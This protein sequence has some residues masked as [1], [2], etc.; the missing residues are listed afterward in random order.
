MKFSLKN[1]CVGVKQSFTWL[2]TGNHS[3]EIRKDQWVCDCDCFWD[4]P[5]A[6]SRICAWEHKEHWSILLWECKVRCLDVDD[7]IGS[8]G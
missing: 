4:V 7:F 8:Q 5:E 1:T 2:E 6:L 3:A